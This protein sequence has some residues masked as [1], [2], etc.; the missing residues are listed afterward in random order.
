MK[1]IKSCFLLTMMSPGL[2]FAQDVQ[3]EG[4]MDVPVALSA[5]NTRSAPAA[6]LSM[7]HIRFMKL[8]LST[9]AEKSIDKRLHKTLNITSNATTAPTLGKNVQLG[10]NNVPV[11]D[12]GPFGTCVTFATTAAIDAAL[13]KG[14]YVSQL[15]SLQLGRY[16]ENNAYNPSGWDGSWGSIVL[17]QFNVFG[18][19]NKEKEHA[20]G[21]G[22][23]T[24]YPMTRLEVPPGSEM[25]PEAC[26]S[27]SE[28]LLSDDS[29]AAPAV[30][31]SSILDIYQTFIDGPNMDVVL[32]QVKSSLNQQDRLTFGVA[33][34]G[35]YLG[36][37]GAVGKYHQASDTWVITP[38]V[39]LAYETDEELAG[40][41]MI[42]T[43][44]ND[45]AVAVDNHGVSHKGLLT[46]RNSWGEG[47]GDKGNFYMSYSYFKA[48]A[49]EIQRIRTLH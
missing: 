9:K 44:Y 45:D 31:W 25:A 6:S 19:V 39:I 10:M 46:L 30:L 20:V 35:V 47:I 3:I 1:L 2:L 48:L 24:A 27:M 12:Q 40:H 26:H 22:G 43:G 8:E 15:C 29:E 21:C 13:N 28:S 38:E 49:L 18:I 5:R 14:D 32:N 34:P 33:L 17:N 37:A 23:V 41:E 42:I 7:K 16:L 36:L 4:S 11:L